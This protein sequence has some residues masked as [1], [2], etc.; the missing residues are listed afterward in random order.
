MK[1]SFI[2]AAVL[3]SSLIVIGCGKDPVNFQILEDARLKA[4][5]NAEYNMQRY[6]ASNPQYSSFNIEVQGDSTQ[7]ATCP[8]GDGWA[9]TY[10]LE[11]VT[12]KKEEY[13]CST[14][15]GAINCMTKK[16]FN[17]KPFASDDKICQSTDKVPFPLPSLRK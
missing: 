8:Q 11:P 1:K 17:S 7:T 4:K 12:F 9:T 15:S 5:E 2:L 6:R 10:L 14:V 16:D 3:A 13:R